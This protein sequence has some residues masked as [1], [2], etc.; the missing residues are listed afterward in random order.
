MI[1]TDDVYAHRVFFL[2][3][4][5][6][7]GK[8]SLQLLALILFLGKHQA[9]GCS[10]DIDWH[11]AANAFTDPPKPRAKHLRRQSRKP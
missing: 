8:T 1:R 10:I 7:S 6:F 3:D 9:G 2:G 4:V 11:K 5:T